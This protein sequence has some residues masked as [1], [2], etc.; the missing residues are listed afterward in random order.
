MEKYIFNAFKETKG[1]CEIIFFKKKTNSN[2]RNR[3]LIH[4]CMKLVH[5]LK[6]NCLVVPIQKSHVMW[7]T[8]CLKLWCMLNIHNFSQ[9]H[10]IVNKI[11]VFQIPQ[12]WHIQHW[13]DK[14]LKVEVT[15]CL[16]WYRILKGHIA[17][18]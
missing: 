5:N 18:F 16:Y 17:C 13:T 7:I 10:Q 11:T 9:F 2:D 6:S 1:T 14:S 8:P 15:G 12:K 3:N 4:N